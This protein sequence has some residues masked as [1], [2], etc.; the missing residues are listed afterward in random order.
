MHSEIFPTEYRK[1]VSWKETHPIQAKNNTAKFL[2]KNTKLWRNKYSGK[3]IVLFF[4][5]HYGLP[6]AHVSLFLIRKAE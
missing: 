6:E 3:K 2:G 4:Y 5:R 1:E